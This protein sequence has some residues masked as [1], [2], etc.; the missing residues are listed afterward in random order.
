[1]AYIKLFF[2]ED[3]TQV[4]SVS[5]GGDGEPVSYTLRA[6]Q[7]EVGEWTG[8]YAKSDDGYICSTVAITLTGASA[9]KWQLC[10]DDAG[11]PDEENAEDYGD[12]LSL[13][14]VDD[15][16]GVPFW[17]RAKA[18]DDESPVNDTTV[19]LGAIG[20]ATAE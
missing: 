16:T 10:P 14:T 2:T 8:L 12:P 18:T 17:I 3:D 19:I 6:D 11:E 13:G 4:E 15:T 9:T 20:I 1:M 5:P 7:N